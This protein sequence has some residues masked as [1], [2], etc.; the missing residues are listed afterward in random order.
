[1]NRMKKRTV[2][3]IVHIGALLAVIFVLFIWYA[4]ENNKRILNLNKKLCGRF[5]MADCTADRIRIG[6]CSL[7]E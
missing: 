1:M 4:E 5:C 2:Q 6:K 3:G 7:A